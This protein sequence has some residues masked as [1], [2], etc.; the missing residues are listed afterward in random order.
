MAFWLLAAD[1]RQAIEQARA[2][3]M[4]PSAEAQIAYEARYGFADGDTSRV[5]TTAGDVAE[6]RVSGVITDKPDLMAMLFGGGNVTWPEIATALV[7][8]DSDPAVKRIELSVDSP[9]GSI[10]GMFDAIAA[11]QAVRKPTRAV[12]R[13]KAAS[14]AYALIS[15]ADEIVATNRAVR[16]GSVGIVA[17]FYNDENE[18]QVTSTQAPKKRPDVTT[19]EGKAVVRE[20]LDAIHELMVEAIATGR[21]STPEKVNAE[22][23]QGAMLLA[24][25]AAK[26]GMVD[27]VTGAP[28]LR[29]VKPVKPTSATTAQQ[30]NIMDL[31]E[32]KAAHPAVYAAAVADGV[33]QERDRV[34][35]H[36]IMGEASG[37][38]A[39]ALKAAKEGTGMTATLQATYMAAGIA[40]GETSNRTADDA[41]AAAALAAAAAPQ[42][43]A[44]G[45]DAVL[46]LV[47][48]SLGIVPGA[49]I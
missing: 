18:I 4:T 43:E 16:F 31:N 29:V 45:S 27:S 42:T 24:D 48:A 14:A 41:A 7:A 23:G 12:V 20:E 22:F 6:I 5:L 26:R 1:V 47:E 21:K 25:E 37:D 15:Q 17:G 35:A 28:A 2:A 33:T 46:A 34:S 11:M 3:G 9:G 44:A 39:T 32:L 36:L 19:E 13:N 8:A 40:R 38:M 49:K 10:D 30:E